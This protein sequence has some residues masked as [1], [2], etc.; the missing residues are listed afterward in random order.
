MIEVKKKQ[1]E[2]SEMLLRRFN[3]IVQESGL[4]KAVKEARFKAK[5]P[6]RRERREMAKRRMLL[7]KLRNEMVSYQTKTRTLK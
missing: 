5:F 2:K 6:N 1:N 7:R 4:L 3:R